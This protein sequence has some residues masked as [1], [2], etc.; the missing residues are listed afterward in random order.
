MKRYGLKKNN[1]TMK[2]LPI[3]CVIFL[4]LLGLGAILPA[5]TQYNCDILDTIMNKDF[6]SKDDASDPALVQ[7]W[8][9]CLEKGF[10]P[11]P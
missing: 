3:S 9:D 10:V 5:D 11:K 6:E 2:V 1:W 8:N 7:A 4:G